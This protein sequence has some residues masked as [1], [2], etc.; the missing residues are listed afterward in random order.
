[1]NLRPRHSGFTLIELLV[2]ISIIILLLGISLPSL[3]MARKAAY[4]I[5]ARG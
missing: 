4:K 1:M 3:Q 2:V 5:V